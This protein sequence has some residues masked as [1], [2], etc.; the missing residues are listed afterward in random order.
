MSLVPL[1]PSA[2]KLLTDRGLFHLKRLSAETGTEIDAVPAASLV[3]IRA[4]Y[5]HGD[6]PGIVREAK[7]AV[8]QFVE[9]H[10]VEVS[11]DLART[12]AEISSFWSPR[13]PPPPP[14]S[15]SSPYCSSCC[16]AENNDSCGE[17]SA[18]ENRR[19]AVS[20]GG[21]SE[22]VT[23]D[24]G[25]ATSSSNSGGANGAPNAKLRGGIVVGK[26]VGGVFHPRKIGV[27]KS[28][29]N[30][31]IRRMAELY[32]CSVE[33]IVT[34]AIATA[35]ATAAAGVNGGGSATSAFPSSSKSKA[36]N[37]HGSKNDDSR[38]SE[39]G[40]DS[41]AAPVAAAIPSSLD[42]R[43]QRLSSTQISNSN[44]TKG[45]ST[46]KN[47]Y[48]KPKKKNDEKNDGK[49]QEDNAAV[50]AEKVAVGVGADANTSGQG[51]D[52]HAPVVARS[53]Q[54]RNIVIRGSPRLVENAR[55]AIVALVSG[56]SRCEVLL[57]VRFV[58][59]VDIGKGRLKEIQARFLFK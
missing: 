23:G 37:K 51:R 42:N 43:Q 58:V 12:F 45:S 38:S 48:S 20:T 10:R 44:K 54:P 5:H 13:P 22:P 8:W 19:E 33:F 29:S 35:T 32:G 28:V 16:A 7:R 24:G 6:S 57:G 3:R 36:S 46:R 31:L 53:V 41:V 55:N 21:V 34:P 30:E 27:P 9:N 18:K 1:P 2:M 59:A 49:R 11:V 39:S 47:N 52:S 15:S 40:G 26:G 56:H 17:V 50:P 25:G 4:K 14:S